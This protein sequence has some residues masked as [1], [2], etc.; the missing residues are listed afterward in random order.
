MGWE[1]RDLAPVVTPSMHHDALV[2]GLPSGPRVSKMT[3]LRRRLGR[4]FTVTLSTIVLGVALVPAT[5]SASEASQVLYWYASTGGP[6]I[7]ALLAAST[8]FGKGQYSACSMFKSV[9]AGAL[10]KPYPPDPG[11]AFHWGAALAFYVA[12]GGECV[13][14]IQHKDPASIAAAGVSITDANDQI[15]TVTA[16]VKA[17]S[18]A[19]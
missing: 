7:T 14:G 2:T 17:D 4:Q 11:I 6:V 3:S 15:R 19:Q 10:A 5:A 18:D 13:F 9:A 16:G 1:P 12:G 8:N